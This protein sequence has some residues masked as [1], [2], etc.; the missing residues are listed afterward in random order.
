M[1]SLKESKRLRLSWKGGLALFLGAMPV[2]WLF[3]RF[4][5]YDL[6]RPTLFSALVVGFAVAWKW[7]LR[8]RA[9]FWAVMVALVA[10][11]LPIILY[12]PWTTRWIPAL[13][14]MPFLY[15][16]FALMTTIVKR[17]EKHFEKATTSGPSLR[18]TTG[19]SSPRKHE[20]DESD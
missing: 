12:V 10:L 14:A 16:D 15:A 19:G 11:H 1:K 6:A 8:G 4:G 18:P 3:D 13:V 9:W 20:I 2:A 5:R 7:E 17:L